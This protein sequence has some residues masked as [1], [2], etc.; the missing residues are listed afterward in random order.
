MENLLLVA[1]AARSVITGVAVGCW[2]VLRGGWISSRKKA[3]K[4]V[5]NNRDARLP[6]EYFDG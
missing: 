4:A 6:Q 5:A 2:A 1:S 3:A